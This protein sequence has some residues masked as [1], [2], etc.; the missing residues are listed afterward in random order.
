[1]A[2]LGLMSHHLFQNAVSINLT[3][4][5]FRLWAVLEEEECLSTKSVNNISL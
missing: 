5:D 1:M 4:L 3:L 2:T